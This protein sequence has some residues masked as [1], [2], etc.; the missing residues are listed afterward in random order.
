MPEDVKVNYLE[1]ASIYKKS[2]RGA[3]VLLRLALQKLCKHLGGDGDNINDDLKKL[4][5]KDILSK[6]LV[7]VADTIRITGNNAI[8]PG[9]IDDRDV[10]DIAIKLFDFLNIIVRKAITEPKE[11]KSFYDSK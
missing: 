6:T 7:K 9:I 1:A 3:A 2:P 11:I 8:N 10:D 5:D 4:A